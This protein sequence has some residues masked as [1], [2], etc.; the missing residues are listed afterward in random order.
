MRRRA[1]WA[2]GF[3]VGLGACLSLDDYTGGAPPGD[4]GGGPDVD[5]E[6][7][8]SGSADGAA[9]DA[10]AADADRC[11]LDAGPPMVHV[12]SFCIDATLVSMAEYAPFLAAEPFGHISAE[13]D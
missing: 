12:E 2:A 11:A 1:V 6:R 3:V 9:I 7:D 13:Q 10:N 4:A 8:S 5:S